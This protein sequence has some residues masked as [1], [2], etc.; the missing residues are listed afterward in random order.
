MATSARLK[1][2]LEQLEHERNL[3]LT[4][5]AASTE[6]ASK[7]ATER[8]IAA[9]LQQA[10]AHASAEKNELIRVL[11]TANELNKKQ[12]LEKD[13]T[14]AEAAAAKVQIAD[15]VAKLAQLASEEA[16]ARERFEKEQQVNTKAKEELQEAKNA[17]VVANRKIEELTAGQ[18]EHMI[19]EDGEPVAENSTC[20]L[21]VQGKIAS[22]HKGSNTWT[23]ANLSRLCRSADGSLEPGRCFEEI[24]KGGVNWG[25]GTTWVTSNALA[26]CGGTPNARRT[27]DCFKRQISSGQTWQVAIRQCRGK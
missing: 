18:L 12:R 3:R 10:L 4:A 13:Q 24:V 27:L 19:P 22:S 6:A 1:H 20:V 16:L 25:A 17:L 8:T 26:L 21:A 5:E 11:E 15:A 23:T 14:G 2:T 9:Q 7:L